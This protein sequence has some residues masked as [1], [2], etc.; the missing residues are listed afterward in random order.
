MGKILAV[1]YS[2]TGNNRKVVESI[3]QLLICDVEEI[4]DQKK[5]MGFINY[6]Y[7]GRDALKARST[8][9]ATPEKDPGKYDLVILAGPV[10]AGSLTPALRTYLNTYGKRLKKTAFIVTM[11]GSGEKK[12]LQAM[13]DLSTQPEAILVLKVGEIGKRAGDSKIKDFVNK[14]K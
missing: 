6:M 9:I 7:G 14:L 3:Q 10:W 11:G 2:R 12:V 5:R 8:E 1:Y 13:K 4:R